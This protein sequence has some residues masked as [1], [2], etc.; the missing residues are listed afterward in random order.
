[1]E[2]KMHESEA[3]FNAAMS[4]LLLT[5]GNAMNTQQV[6]RVL[7]GKRRS[8]TLSRWE[9][10]ISGMWPMYGPPTYTGSED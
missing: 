7:S 9:D 8:K 5:L 10:E 3:K 4:S 1:M 2:T 6:T